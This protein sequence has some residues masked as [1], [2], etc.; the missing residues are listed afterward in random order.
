MLWFPLLRGKLGRAAVWP[1][2]IY[3]VAALIT[4]MIMVSNFDTLAW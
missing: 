4:T 2:L 3:L 1:A